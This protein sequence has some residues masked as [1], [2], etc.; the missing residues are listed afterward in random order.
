MVRECSG[1]GM[2]GWWNTA[3]N[4]KY[5]F[6]ILKKSNDLSQLLCWHSFTLYQWKDCCDSSGWCV[7]T[8]TMNSRRMMQDDFYYIDVYVC[9]YNAYIYTYIIYPSKEKNWR[10]KIFDGP[11]S[12]HL[13]WCFSGNLPWQGLWIF[14]SFSQC[15]KSS[16]ASPARDGTTPNMATDH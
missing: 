5:V 1:D 2:G 10:I 7:L 12:H 4:L 6:S 9:I 3:E 8:C 14:K 11:S 16:F 15:W 13:C